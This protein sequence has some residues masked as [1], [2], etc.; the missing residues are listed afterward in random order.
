MT[1]PL[2]AYLTDQLIP[3]I[4]NKRKL[5]PLI[6]EAIGHT[7]IARAR[8]EAAVPAAR[9]GFAIPPATF[10]D[11]FAGSGV[12]SRL[13]KTM[14][15]RVIANDWEPYSEIINAAYIGSNAPPP[16]ARLGGIESA[17]AALN[18][19]PG[20]AGY[21]AD[22][23]C[24][25]DDERYDILTERMFYTQSNGRRIDAIREHIL[26][27]RSEGV[28]DANEESVL[29]APLIYQAAYCSNTSGVFKGFHNGWGGA[30]MTAWYRIRSSLTLRPPVFFDN[31]VENLV[32][33]ADAAALAGEIE[34][35]IAYLDP[36]YNQHQY[37]SNYHL[38]N[39]VA[40]WD[41]P[42]INP[43]ISGNGVRDKAAIRQ[44]W[45]TLRRSPYCHKAAA[46]GAFRDLVGRLRA[47]YILVSYSTDGIMGVEDLLST[48]AERGALSVVRKQYK[49]Y[50]VSSQRPSPRQHTVEFVAIVDTRQASKQ[51]AVARAVEEIETPVLSSE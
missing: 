29:L 38:L 37:G 14:G 10:F 43:R 24:P 12:V 35:D 15:F 8:A 23:Y 46:L 49:R 4:G 9:A 40:L 11:V 19:L 18:A 42:P 47:R 2:G 21:I 45:R 44:D 48:L 28:I 31:G 25:A 50:R 41:K 3:Y 34:C 30:T 13:A 22:H 16:F 32:F 7:G 33:R 20:E 39:T 27:W 5:L 1:E 26:R 17:I 6:T 51:E 36:P